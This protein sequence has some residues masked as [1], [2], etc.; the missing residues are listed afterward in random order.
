MA[1]ENALLYQIAITDEL[2]GL[3]SK[4]HFL[5]SIEKRFALY[6]RYGEKMTLLMLDIDDFKKINDTYGHPAGDHILKQI[7][8]T[9]M[10]STRGGDLD[11]RY[12]GEEF[13]VIL[14]ATDSAWGVFV[15]E[16]IRKRIEG[17]AF[18]IDNMTVNLTVSIGVASCPEHAVTIKDL[19][20]KADRAL[21]EAKRNGKNKV[22]LTEERSAP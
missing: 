1:F 14:P 4:R 21:Y 15:A 13:T 12:G 5:S 7:G 3:Y 19:I 2:T 9:V 11:F 20:V 16:R 22:V 8:R 18:T 17:E 10:N 6:E